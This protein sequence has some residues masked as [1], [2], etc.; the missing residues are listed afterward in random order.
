MTYFPRI[1]SERPI[2]RGSRFDFVTLTIQ[3]PSGRTLDRDIVRHPGAVVVVPLLNQ[4][5]KG[6]CVVLIRN[7]R[8]AIGESLVEC[9]AGTIER[10]RKPEGG[11]GIAEDPEHCA[12]R[13]LIEETGYQ[14]SVMRSLGWF[15]TTPGLTDE[16]MF[17]FVATGLTHVGQKL[18]EDETI[19]VDVVPVQEALGMIGDGRIRDAKSIVALTLAER[20]GYL[21]N[22]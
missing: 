13:E 17:A 5:G 18:E 1:I 11:F 2:H 9:C 6:P 4:P 3:R 8:I 19:E 10:A 20:G 22:V 14:A 16:Q 21:R 7:Y 15:Y 12:R